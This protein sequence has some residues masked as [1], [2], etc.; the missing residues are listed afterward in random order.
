MTKS[1]KSS[2]TPP[3]PKTTS[4]K[5]GVTRSFSLSAEL[6]DELHTFQAH[7]QRSRSSIVVD[8]IRIYLINHAVAEKK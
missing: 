8:A 1:K 3:G 2:K 4:L 6:A 5:K 7:T